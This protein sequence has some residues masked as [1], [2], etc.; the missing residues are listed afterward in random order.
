MDTDDG[1]RAGDA[2]EESDAVFATLKNLR[3]RSRRQHPSDPI[4]ETPPP[5]KRQARAGA[6]A[7]ADL[8]ENSAV[9][10]AQTV[11]G[12]V[13]ATDAS[14]VML[15]NRGTPSS[16][17]TTF[18]AGAAGPGI[19]PAS[20][21]GLSPLPLVPSPPA[22]F[23]PPAT[24]VGG[25][26][27]A[28]L[29]ARPSRRPRA[30]DDGDP[31]SGR[32]VGGVE[33]PRRTA[34]A[35]VSR[36]LADLPASQ[37][38]VSPILRPPF[39]ADSPLGAH[40]ESVGTDPD[41]A[42]AA[43]SVDT[44]A[45]AA[46]AKNV[47]ACDLCATQV[48]R[49]LTRPL[50]L[51]QHIA[52]SDD[53]F[54]AWSRD[55]GRPLVEGHAD[56]SE[57]CCLPC[58]NELNRMI[59][60]TICVGCG[61]SVEG[62]RKNDEQLRKEGWRSADAAMTAAVRRLTTYDGQVP[63]Y[64][65]PSRPSLMCRL[66]ASCAYRERRETTPAPGPAV[67]SPGPAVGAPARTIGLASTVAP[68]ARPEERGEKGVTVRI[69][70]ADLR[71]EAQELRKELL[72]S[73]HPLTDRKLMSY[74]LAVAAY[75]C[76]RTAQS[77]PVLSSDL[78][79]Q[80]VWP[81]YTALGAEVLRDGHAQGHGQSR[82][83]KDELK[84]KY[85]P[86]RLVVRLRAV[87]VGDAGQ[88][89]LF[90]STATNMNAPVK[91]CVI[92]TNVEQL[93]QALTQR[94]T[95]DGLTSTAAMLSEVTAWAKR[96]CTPAD[97][98]TAKDENIRPSLM[99]GASL[100]ALMATASQECPVLTRF[101]VALVP[102]RDE[103]DEAKSSGSGRVEIG[104]TARPTPTPVSRISA[105]VSESSGP[106]PA[107][108]RVSLTTARRA[109]LL[110]VM[111]FATSARATEP[112]HSVLAAAARMDGASE[113]FMTLLNRLGACVSARTAHRHLAT[114]AQLRQR[115]LQAGPLVP[116]HNFA[117]G[118]LD[119]LDWTA[120]TR[121]YG[122]EAAMA[123]LVTSILMHGFDPELP[124]PDGDAVRP[125][126]LPPASE[127]LL[128]MPTGPESAAFAE[129]RKHID[130][131][132]AEAVSGRAARVALAPPPSSAAPAQ[133]GPLAVVNVRMDTRAI[134][135][136]KVPADA[137]TAANVKAA[138][139]KTYA[140]HGLRAEDLSLTIDGK[141][142]PDDVDAAKAG[143]NGDSLVAASSRV[144]SF[145]IRLEERIPHDPS[146][147]AVSVAILQPL[148]GHSSDPA[149]IE[150]TVNQMAANAG[151]G[152]GESG[153]QHLVCAGDFQTFDIMLDIKARSTKHDYLVPWI[154]DWHL[155]LHLQC[156]VIAQYWD[157]G[158]K[159]LAIFD[160]GDKPGP[161]AY[162][163][164]GKKFEDNAVFLRRVADTVGQ[165]MRAGELQY[166]P[167][168]VAKRSGEDTTFAMWVQLLDD[169]MA[170][171]AL[172]LAIR[173]ANFDLR[174]ASIKRLSWLFHV[175]GK[176]NYVRLVSAHLK[177]VAEL[178][179]YLLDLMRRHFSVSVWGHPHADSAMD[180]AL[181]KTA[182]RSA[183]GVVRSVDG[184]QAQRELTAF[185]DLHDA[186]QQLQ[187]QLN[188]G[189]RPNTLS[190]AYLTERQ[191]DASFDKLF[192]ALAPSKVRTE[193]V[194]VLSGVVAHPAA[195]R[196]FVLAKA[197]GEHRLAR[198][199][200][201]HVYGIVPPPLTPS[202]KATFGKLPN[203][204]L[205]LTARPVT[206]RKKDLLLAARDN[207]LEVA[208]QVMAGLELERQT[209]ELGAQL[210][211][212]PVSEAFERVRAQV[213]REPMCFT[214][215]AGT[216]LH[217]N[218]AAFAKQLARLDGSTDG[219]IFHSLPPGW[220]AAIVLR[221][222][223]VDLHALP[224]GGPTFGDFVRT[225]LDELV[226]KAL[227]EWGALIVVLLCD[228]PDGLNV[229]KAMERAIRRLNRVENASSTTSLR[230]ITATTPLPPRSRWRND[231]ISNDTVRRALIAFI[232]QYAMTEY[233]FPEGVPVG[234]TLIFDAGD[235]VPVQRVAGVPGS[236]APADLRHACLEADYSCFFVAKQLQ[237]RAAAA[238]L[239]EPTVL[240]TSVD[241][242]IWV[243][244][245]LLCSSG[246][247]QC[248]RGKL[249]IAKTKVDLLDVTELVERLRQLLPPGVRVEELVALFVIS[250]C[251][252]T[253][254]WAGFTHR[255]ML[256]SYLG[257][258]DDLVRCL[259]RMG[260]LP[261]DGHVHL[262]VFGEDGTAHIDEAAYAVFVAYLHFEKFRTA[263]KPGEDF[264]S[265]VPVG[266]AGTP[267]DQC[268]ALYNIVKTRTMF[269]TREQRLRM[270]S[271]E[272]AAFHRL[273]ADFVL[274]LPF[275]GLR[276]GARFP[277][278]LAHGYTLLRP[279]EALSATNLGVRWDV[280]AVSAVVASASSVKCGCK[281]GCSTL[282]CACKKGKQYCTTACRCGGCTNGVGSATTA[283]DDTLVRMEV[284]NNAP[285]AA[286]RRGDVMGEEDVG[287]VSE[288]E[289][290]K[291]EEEEEEEEDEEDEEAEKEE[292]DV[293]EEGED[294]WGRLAHLRFVD[295]SGAS[296]ETA[297]N[298]AEE[299]L[300]E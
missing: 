224:H 50:S 136:V 157:L 87:D 54:A 179:P 245:L 195:A 15:E 212:T 176:H 151:V 7:A 11:L 253:S 46:G 145:R 199:I 262:A 182:N 135:S 274:Q 125:R 258:L 139:A 132:I 280:L 75:E 6:S 272:A 152:Q 144:R 20:G 297:E 276:A 282:R 288:E 187:G 248:G 44:P 197:L 131:L 117:M 32:R 198:H 91:A 299:V 137:I 235:G 201:R 8:S 246:A 5:P 241:T 25:S 148:V 202:E 83:N 240:I 190:N 121:G 2:Q 193:I 28:T 42:G 101:L 169:V 86:S 285:A 85:N 291:E 219:D 290:G 192:A 43:P 143:A 208:R 174:Q 13:R 9:G 100:D 247:Y 23:L 146:A 264:T 57:R 31:N 221:D 80:F 140:K 104:S 14:D 110:S 47:Y 112:L 56:R 250:G 1:E 266:A 183:K 35:V 155:L 175:Q 196:Q 252:Y 271:F 257:G 66:C 79:E 115:T 244:A 30:D 278:V 147:H 76:V 92:A 234:T 72:R 73:K 161:L 284:D 296:G 228:N 17:G 222:L 94:R 158:L 126:K 287:E 168:F 58:Y 153:R 172:H 194:N 138:L 223:L 39:G 34:S 41:A 99:S 62:K 37:G 180:E 130:E 103:P 127:P 256:E 220:K 270:P 205:T 185:P 154:G 206:A 209:L 237:A 165:I 64:V 89:L 78:F 3:R 123:H 268:R 213:M 204:L 84:N 116:A 22:P 122:Q 170:V 259:R 71:A 45:A 60:M 120:A 230:T 269:A 95:E 214:D 106:G 166:G 65:R 33:Q 19:A 236:T 218:K 242:D 232:R 286:A 263:F 292:E 210:E 177:Q 261:P 97:A 217:A 4:L 277:D 18:P 134:V 98:R 243:Y 49:S 203:K 24:P 255:N 267:A 113:T 279:L 293:G 141:D 215:G 74:L 142:W 281:K 294:V 231:V 160:V 90:V 189:V 105:R 227:T 10:I 156:N 53:E 114:I 29:T 251:D 36:G 164:A 150:A 238:G 229:A 69:T 77:E 96:H 70:M 186:R 283:R 181:E 119:N 273:R 40:G 118:A 300:P 239:P 184:P 178:S 211:S 67:A 226:T 27:S 173:T 124:D 133:S 21:A 167:D 81:A 59:E 128:H 12:P 55:Q 52:A 254:R 265:L 249:W 171:N 191:V 68:P 216:K 149:V 38:G 51:E 163:A 295:D 82:L 107:P 111:A 162:L 88:P 298:D 159:E 93:A 289:D 207:E 63:S 48:A 225:F 102:D 109:Y 260:A 129:Y 233:V 61:E 16:F 108:V 188:V 275:V 26:A 200:L